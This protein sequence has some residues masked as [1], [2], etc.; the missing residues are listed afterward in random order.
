MFRSFVIKC[1]KYSNEKQFIFSETVDRPF[2]RKYWRKICSAIIRGVPAMPSYMRRAPAVI[3][4][5][6]CNNP[7]LVQGQIKTQKKRF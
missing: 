6:G 4:A 7:F 3:F 5:T 1:N 2:L